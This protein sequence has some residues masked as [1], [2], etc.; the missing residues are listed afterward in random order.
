VSTEDRVIRQSVVRTKRIVLGV[1]AILE[2][3]TYY[4]LTEARFSGQGLEPSIVRF[5]TLSDRVSIVLFLFYLFLIIRSIFK[6]NRISLRRIVLCTI[7]LAIIFWITLGAD[8]FEVGEFPRTASFTYLVLR[9]FYVALFFARK[10]YDFH[11][12]AGFKSVIRNT[13]LV[14]ATAILIA[15]FFSFTYP[16]A[17]QMQEIRQY[18]PDAAVILGAAVWH[19]SSLGERP[20]PTLAERINTGAELINSGAVPKLVVTGSNAPNERSEAEVA[21]RELVAKGIDAS[22]IVTES[23]SRSTIE[24]VIYIRDELMNRQQWKRFVIV[25]DQYHLARVLE[26]CKF[27]GIDAIGMASGIKQEF[28]DLLYYRLRESIALIAYWIL[29]K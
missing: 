9:A 23:S 16:Y 15:F 24:Q 2:C 25:S 18:D 20:S 6:P 11:R 27:N 13:I 26:M 22:V 12:W 28:F 5:T 29:G 4:Y 7:V 8:N 14:F 17:S 1:A 3:L 10:E 21:K 19:G